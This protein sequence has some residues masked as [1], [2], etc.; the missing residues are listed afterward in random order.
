MTKLDLFNPANTDDQA[1]LLAYHL[2][3]GWIWS[4]AFD[5]NGNLGKLVR[6]LAVEFYRLEVLTQKITTEFDINQTN[7]LLLEWEKSVG[8]PDDCFLTNTDLVT[9][10]LQVLQKFSNFGGVQ[11]ASDFVRVAQVF[12]YNITVTP[13]TPESLFPLEFPIIFFADVREATHTILVEFIDPPAG[14]EFFP[15]PFPLPF[16]KG[17]QV[18]LQCIFNVLAPANV[19]VLFTAL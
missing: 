15:L 9:R 13:T 8:I 2:P 6:G 12:G 14:E 11:K 16:N 18:F 10:R 7:E 19:Q 5:P 1:Q 4:S 3:I 17:A